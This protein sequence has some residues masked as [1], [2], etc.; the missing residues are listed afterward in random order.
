M[1]V[2]S[3]TGFATAVAKLPGS[4][5]AAGA[6]TVDVRSVNGRFLDLSFRLPD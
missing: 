1:P 3:M 6:V 2:Y 4:D 5:G